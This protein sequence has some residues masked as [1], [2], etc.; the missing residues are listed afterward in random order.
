MDD[1][2]YPSQHFPFGAAFV[3]HAGNFWTLLRI[4]FKLLSRNIRPGTE[5]NQDKPQLRQPV[6]TPKQDRKPPNKKSATLPTVSLRPPFLILLTSF[7][8]SFVT[9][10]KKAATNLNARMSSG[11]IALVTG[12]AGF[13]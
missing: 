10:L 7:C 1:T 6:S 11:F 8:Q 9:G 4:N 2:I 3:C 13:W 5:G 12:T